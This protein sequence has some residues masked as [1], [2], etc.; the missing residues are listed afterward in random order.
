MDRLLFI[1]LGGALGTL[2]RHGVSV[3]CAQMFGTAFP[4]GTLAINFI[5]SFL[6]GVVMKLSL[7]TDFLS[8]TVRL[9]LGTGVLGGFTTYSTFSYETFTFLRDG[10]WL[11]G[12]ANALLTLLGCLL[13]TLLGVLAVR[14][15]LGG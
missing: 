1:G 15:L 13:A 8:P 11:T 10:A 3:W 9:A 7:T 2:A 5:G 6:L 14:R 4:Y 12:I